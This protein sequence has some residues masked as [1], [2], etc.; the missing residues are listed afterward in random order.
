MFYFLNHLTWLVAREDFIKACLLLNSYQCFRGAFCH[1][2]S[3][4]D[5]DTYRSNAKVTFFCVSMV[6]LIVTTQWTVP[7][8]Y[9]MIKLVPYRE[10]CVPS[11]ETTIV[12]FLFLMEA[13]GVRDMRT[14]FL[15]ITTAQDINTFILFALM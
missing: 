1:H 10:Q 15:Y 2:I 5:S 12:N 9:I 8:M 11:S 4:D 14:E 13:C 6:A 7:I 3:I